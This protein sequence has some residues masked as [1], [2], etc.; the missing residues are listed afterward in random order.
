MKFLFC[1]DYRSFKTIFKTFKFQLFAS[2]VHLLYFWQ[3]HPS[4]TLRKRG[5]TRGCVFAHDLLV[6]LVSD[7]RGASCTV[8]CCRFE[9]IKCLWILRRMQICCQ[10][11][12][13]FQYS[14]FCVGAHHV[15]ASPPLCSAP[16]CPRATCTFSIVPYSVTG[17]S[18]CSRDFWFFTASFC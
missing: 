9:R 8:L 3:V 10:Y 2:S 7:Q 12:R 14:E 5:C 16:V 17:A 15:S 11:S 4:S 13:F 6:A 1:I 18:A